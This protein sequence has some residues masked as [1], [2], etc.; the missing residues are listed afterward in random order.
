RRFPINADDRA[1]GLLR[2]HL[3]TVGEEERLRREK[4]EIEAR[5]RE[6]LKSSVA[7]EKKIRNRWRRKNR[8]KNACIAELEARVRELERRLGEP[9]A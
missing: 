1:T 5:Y 9:E 8:E 7:F 6:V 4:A 2:V 3:R